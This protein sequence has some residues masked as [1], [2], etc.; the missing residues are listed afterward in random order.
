[1]MNPTYLIPMETI[2]H[3]AKSR[4]MIKKQKALDPPNDLTSID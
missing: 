1:M 3:G 4:H 2:W